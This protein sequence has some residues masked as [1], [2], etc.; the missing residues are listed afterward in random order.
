M[1]VLLDWLQRPH[2]K[3]WWDD[4]DD[5]LAKVRRHYLDNSGAEDS[6]AVHRFIILA[7]L[8][9]AG[10][11]GPVGY[12]QY[13]RDQDYMPDTSAVGIDLFLSDP[14]NLDHGLG[15]KVVQ[16]F[17]QLILQN[18]PAKVILVD[19]SPGNGRAI[20]CYEKAGFEYRKIVETRDH[21]LHRLMVL[22]RP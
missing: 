17:V 9:P 6:A 4:G 8:D 2:V 21:Q 19:P 1:P 7:R 16:D 13:Y 22:Y 18:E 14:E 3:A 11:N 15:L 20:R 12:I 5:T 10:I